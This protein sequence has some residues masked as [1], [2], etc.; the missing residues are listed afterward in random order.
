HQ[1]Q[2]EEGG[3]AAVDAYRGDFFSGEVLEGAAD[4]ALEGVFGGEVGVGGPA[5]GDTGGE[6]RGVLAGAVHVQRV[7]V[8]VP[9][10]VEVGEGVGADGEAGGV[11]QGRDGEA[12]GGEDAAD[13]VEV[14]RLA[15]VAGAGQREQFVGEGQAAADHRGGLDGLVG[16]ARVVR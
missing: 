8:A 11:L 9:G 12:G 5:G 4:G 13:A 16:R 14:P 7:G 15:G 6:H 10:G 1:G 2:R 3:A